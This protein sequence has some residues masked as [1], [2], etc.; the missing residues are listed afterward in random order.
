[1]AMAVRHHFIGLFGGGI[2]AHGVI[3]PILG[4]ERNFGVCAI[5]ARGAPID[6]VLNSMLA[7]AHRGC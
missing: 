4:R 5:N 2:E 6:K 1:M 7:T 3:C